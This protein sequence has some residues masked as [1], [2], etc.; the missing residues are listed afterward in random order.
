MLV[1]VGFFAVRTSSCLFLQKI[2][3]YATLSMSKF[4]EPEQ[5][6]LIKISVIIP[7][8]NMEKLLSRCLDSL[9]NQTLR[10]IEI[11]CVND[12]STDKSLDILEK[13]AQ[14]DPRITIINQQNRGNGAARNVALGMA[15]GEYVGFVDADDWIDVDFFEKLYLAA[16]KQNADIACASIERI[17]SY[18][19]SKM[20]L[21]FTKE[22]VFSSPEAK[23]KATD[24]PRRCYIWHK[25]Y[26]R[27]ELEKHHIMFRERVYFE[28]MYFSYQALYL[29]KDMVVVPD[30]VYHYWVNTESIIRTM[31]DRKQQDYINAR[32]E[33]I[34]FIEK[35]SIICDEKCYVR[36]KIIHCFCG[37][38]L[39]EIR[40]WK[41][42]KRYYLFRLLKIWEIKI[43]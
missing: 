39:M 42:V 2:F 31:T 3:H 41:T 1:L 24:V 30:I 9:I 38:P 22:E 23:Y 21:K 37:I 14:K 8:Y 26:R 36:R 40:E 34:D 27:S 18:G 4:L 28:D 19:R 5:M 15:V 35:H 7:V 16:K 20:L 6:N 17:Y 29:L 32:L 10:E 43:S 33:F 13:Y 12:G 25:I 11:I